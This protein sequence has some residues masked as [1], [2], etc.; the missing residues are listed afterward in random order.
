MIKALLLIFK[1]VPTW[2]RIAI[3]Q[4]SW[5]FVLTRY[6]LPLL[7]LG[8]AAEGCGLA[9]WGKPRGKMAHV[10]T[11]SIPQ[12]ILFEIAQLIVS[13]VVVW[14]GARLIRA[15]GE[16]FHGRHSFTQAFTVAAYGLSPLF[17]LRLLDAFP[18]VSP[19]VPWGIGIVLSAA[20]LYHGLPRVMMPDPPHTF[21]LYLM[22]VV[23][24]VMISGLACFL[25][26]W[27]LEGRFTRLDAVIS[28]F[29]PS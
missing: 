18:S 23:L 27:Y 29:L 4:R 2:D 5:V 28:R 15:L 19:W 10:T 20:T 17:F 13:L 25:T 8:C 14:L 21:G 22:S 24:L 7:L 16:T 3:A 6:L 9:H 11:L 12:T 1:S 26:T